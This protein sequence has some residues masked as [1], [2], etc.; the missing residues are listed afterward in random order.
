MRLLARIRNGS[1]KVRPRSHAILR[2]E[3]GA[4][5]DREDGTGEGTVWLADVG[6]GGEGLLEPVPLTGGT[7]ARQGGWSFL[8]D[9]ED[10][11][12]W[13][14]RSPHPDGWFDL[15]AFTLEAQPYADFVVS[16]Y[17]TSTNP[18]SPFVGQVVVQRT[19]PDARHSLQGRDLTVTRPDGSAEH[20]TLGP[21]EFADELET[22][23]GIVLD[24]GETALALRTRGSTG[25]S[26]AAL[27]HAARPGARGRATLCQ[28]RL[29]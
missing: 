14:L 24:V 28:C 12:V 4:E 6:F 17:F 3:V 20:R 22:T 16:N 10:G 7:S 19:A 1:D 2:V 26:A 8:L 13:V 11:G 27:S 25:P 9:R 23:F 5:V 15:Y 29:I 21:E 18:A